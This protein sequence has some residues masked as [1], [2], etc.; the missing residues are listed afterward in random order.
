MAT[1]LSGVV[2]DEGGKPV[3]ETEEEAV[4]AQPGKTLPP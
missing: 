1:R 3:E 4:N 2:A